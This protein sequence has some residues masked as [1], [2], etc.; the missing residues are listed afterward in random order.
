MAKNKKEKTTETNAKKKGNPKA[1][2]SEQHKPG[3]QKTISAPPSMIMKALE[4]HLKDNK[5][6]T[7]IVKNK[8]SYPVT[9]NLCAGKQQRLHIKKGAKIKLN[10]KI[11]TPCKTCPG[12]EIHLMNRESQEVEVIYPQCFDSD[13]VSGLL[14][15]TIQ[16][17]K[18][19]DGNHVK[20]L[21][22]KDIQEQFN[23]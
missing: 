7:Y 3:E 20:T 21:N 5:T 12:R 1:K 23:G 16:I 15:N 4:N 2:S 22:I 17:K 6:E 10:D 18:N 19:H 9:V 11:Q 8:K 13:Q 14:G